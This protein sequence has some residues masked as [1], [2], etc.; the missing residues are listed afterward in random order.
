MSQAGFGGEM[1][2]CASFRTGS[3]GRI[4]QTDL[5]REF[6]SAATIAAEA[7]SATLYVKRTVAAVFI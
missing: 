7:I 3:F 4:P 6:K 5:R 2:A 1:D